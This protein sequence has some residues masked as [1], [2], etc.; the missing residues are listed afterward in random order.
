MCSLIWVALALRPCLA[1]GGA[2]LV[3]VD[4]SASDLLD[5]RSARRLVALELADIEVPPL[6]G[7]ARGP[8]PLF[9]RVLRVDG[10]LRI[11]LWQ[12]GDYLGAR[13]VSGTK[14]GGQLGARRV[15]LAAAELARG[16]Q[17]KRQVQAQRER[18]LAQERANVAAREASRAKDGPLALRPSLAAADIGAL[19]ATL[20]GPRLLGQWTFAP[21]ARLDG[22]FAWL[23]GRSPEAS[24]SEWL[25]LSLSPMRRVSLA[26]SLELDLGANVAAAWLRLGR[27]RGVDRIPD[28][29]ETWSAR[30]AVVVRLE[31]RLTRRVRL[32]VGT[33]MGLLLR[34]VPFQALSGENGRLRG[35]WLG[36]DVG[37]VL[38]PR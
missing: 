28:Q 5:A 32:S 2:V 15:A 16:V 25:E 23:A 36:F 24:R 31:P 1:R 18:A 17:R 14:A 7:K 30:A 11:E 8:A 29:S 22:G 9:F 21:R 27:V 38:T 37:V 4:D 12:R 6:S 20:F 10:D 13:L 3:E 19:S 35:M 33:E 34:E 26:N